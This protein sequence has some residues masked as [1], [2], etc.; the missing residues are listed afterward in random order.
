MVS[1]LLCMCVRVCVCVCV[2]AYQAGCST[3]VAMN[4][5][6]KKLK[7]HAKKISFFD[8]DN[9]MVSLCIHSVAL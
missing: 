4:F 8:I 9:D 5:N 6:L 1:A 7:P 2:R 3:D